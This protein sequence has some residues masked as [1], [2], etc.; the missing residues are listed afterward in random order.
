M[1]LAGDIGGTKTVLALYSPE[2]GPRHPLSEET[3]SSKRYDSLEAI[4]AEF[5][6]KYPR[7][8]THAAFGVAGPVVEDRAEIT[9]LPWQL[10]EKQLAQ[11]FNL[12]AVH[13]LN[14]LEAIATA[15]PILQEGDIHTLNEGEP[16][17]QGAIGIIAPGTGLG[18]AFLVW[19]D[20]RY[21]PFPSEGGHADFAPA[22]EIQIALL[23]YLLTRHQHVSF[24]RVCSG[25]GIPNLYAF[26]QESGR[27]PEPAWLREQL[28][29][30][31]DP[32]PLI[33]RAAQQER[34][35]IAVATLD[36]FMN[37]LAR[38]A[39]NLALKILATGGIYLGG[40]I[41]PRILPQLEASDFM[42]TFTRKGRFG[43]LLNR[44]PVHVIYNRQAALLGTARDGL[45]MM[46]GNGEDM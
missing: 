15:V 43:D 44:V 1:L 34:A 3:F 29:V 10:E 45:N 38:E 37:I 6:E 24:E 32:T 12:E 46:N 42:T 9:N 23:R 25:M 20:G 11:T 7:E 19:H 4:I 5:L 41:P 30:A 13:L 8:I 17:E 31:A 28:A 40:G 22:D 26:F 39:G 21:Q 16:D 18:E 2:K 35:A 27:F 14:D 36:L 33:V